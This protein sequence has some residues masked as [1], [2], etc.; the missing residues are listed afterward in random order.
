MPDFRDCV[1]HLL[2]DWARGVLLTRFVLSMQDFP[3]ELGDGSLGGRGSRSEHAARRRPAVRVALTRAAPQRRRGVGSRGGDG[4]ETR[5]GPGR[6]G[7]TAYGCDG[8][9]HAEVGLRAKCML[10]AN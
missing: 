10:T 9:H 2:V 1:L 8:A 7:K 6:G 5:G 3:V 4:R